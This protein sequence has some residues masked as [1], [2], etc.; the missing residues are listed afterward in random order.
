MLRGG[1]V[2]R[3]RELR[4]SGL[5]VSEIA[6]QTGCDRKTVRKYLDSTEVPRYGP[7]KPGDAPPREPRWA[8]LGAFHAYLDHRMDEGVWSATVLFRELKERGYDG[9]Y[10][11]VKDYV[12]P[13]R[14]DARA[15]AVRRYETPPGKQAQVDWAQIG[16]YEEDGKRRKVYAFAFTLGYSRA[17]FADTATS[18]SLPVFLRLHEAAFDALGGVPEEILYDWMKTVAFGVDERGEV[19]WNPKFTDFAGHWGFCPKLCHPYRPQ[20]KGKIESGVGYIRKSFLTGREVT[21]TS[22]AKRQLQA[23]VFGVANRRLHGTTH[24]I[25][26]EAWQEEKP[27]L[28]P[29]A[30]RPPFP[31]VQEEERKVGRDAFVSY[32]ANRLSVPWSL[33]G[34]LVMVREVNGRIEVVKDGVTVATHPACDKKHQV[35][36]R[37]EHHAGMPYAKEAESANKPMLRFVKE[38]Q[39]V[40]VRALS[41]YEDL[42]SMGG[43]R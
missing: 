26:E 31:Y 6:R 4:E 14:K 23:W 21:D 18:Q 42:L 13:K 34:C 38:A 36:I 20:T 8:K 40:E 27:H 10:T 19:R 35:L 17:L 43:V 25:V 7:R 39:E 11:R 30:G 29:L 32:H 9:G 37:P 16:T 24:R 41:V 3:I 5:T 15:L 33:A 1:N 28:Q 22:D 2:E 12:R